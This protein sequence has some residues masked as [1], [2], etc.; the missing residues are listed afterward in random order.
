VDAASVED[1]SAFAML[2]SRPGARNRGTPGVIFPGSIDKQTQEALTRKTDTQRGDFI[3]PCT[4]S[5][6]RRGQNEA[7]HNK[8]RTAGIQR[9][10]SAIYKPFM[11]AIPCLAL[12]PLSLFF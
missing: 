10:N 2:S 6:V 1:T 5:P 9:R 4:P 11:Y 8:P 7:C 12:W 3:G